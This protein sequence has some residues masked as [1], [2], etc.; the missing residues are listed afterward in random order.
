[1]LGILI[2]NASATICMILLWRNTVRHATDTVK[3]TKTRTV[4]EGNTVRQ[5]V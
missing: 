3:N 5:V 4:F 2:L 1:M